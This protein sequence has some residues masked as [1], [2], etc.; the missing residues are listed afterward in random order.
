MDEVFAAVIQLSLYWW[1]R[2]CWMW[3]TESI[4]LGQIYLVYCYSKFR[5][6]VWEFQLSFIY[7]LY[8]SYYMYRTYNRK[9]RVSVPG[10]R[11]WP[12]RLAERTCTTVEV[13]WVRRELKGLEEAS[14]IVGISW[15]SKQLIGSSSTQK[16][17]D[18]FNATLV[19]LWHPYFAAVVSNGDH[20][21]FPV[22][23]GLRS[24]LI[25]FR[26]AKAVDTQ[27]SWCSDA[28]VRGSLPQ[29]FSCT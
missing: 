29:A 26:L 19:K 24:Q 6:R 15:L 20:E 12:S 13:C 23:G 3:K 2:Y 14:T 17:F 16:K 28:L 25:A 4:D 18:L 1:W 21:T 8:P 5:E 9:D 11:V 10:C 7:L 27:L 22:P